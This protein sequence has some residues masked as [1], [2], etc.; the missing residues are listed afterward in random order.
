MIFFLYMPYANFKLFLDY[1]I[2]LRFPKEY[3]NSHNCSFDINIVKI[4][5]ILSLPVGAEAAAFRVNISPIS[6]R[7]GLLCA[8]C[9]EHGAGSLLVPRLLILMHIFRR[10]FLIFKVFFLVDLFIIAY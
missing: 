8:V 7:N 9:S 5:T 6:T 4:S 3:L 1:I 10:L 2:S